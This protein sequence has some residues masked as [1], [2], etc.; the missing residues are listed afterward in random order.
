MK[1]FLNCY[2]G[3]LY[4]DNFSL[5]EEEKKISSDTKEYTVT[6]KTDED[7]DQVCLGFIDDPEVNIDDCF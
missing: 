4:I 2:D 1:N 7:M 5:S 3:V 6:L